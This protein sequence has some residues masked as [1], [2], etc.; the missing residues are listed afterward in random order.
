M[1]GAG[2]PEVANT[3]IILYLIIVINLIVVVIVKKN[4]SNVGTTSV[5]S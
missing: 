5:L 2:A 4:G 1:A 3:N